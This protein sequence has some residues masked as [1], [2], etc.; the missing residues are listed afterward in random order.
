MKRISSSKA[1]DGLNPEQREAVAYI[2]G[3]LLILAGPGSGKTR[4]IT[5]KIAYLLEQGIPPRA[6]LGVTFTNKAAEEMRSRVET[7][8]GAQ[9]PLR[10]LWLH[11]FHAA[12]AR[13][14]RSHISMLSPKYTPGFTIFD[15]GDQRDAIARVMK[16]LDISAEEASPGFLVSLI[17]RAKDELVGPEDFARRYAGRLD[18]YL[19]EVASRVYR[20]YQALLES[21][22]AVDFGDLLRLTVELFRREPAILERYR[23]RFQYILI[24]EYQDINHAQYVFAKALAQGARSVAVVGDEDQAIFSWRGS[25]PSYILRFREDFPN[26]RVIALKRHYR[27]PH[28]D[29]IFKAAQRLIAHNTQRAREKEFLIEGTGEPIRVLVARDE[30]EEAQ[31]IARE[32]ARLEEQEGVD[33]SQI[34]VLYRINTLSRVIEEAL[35]YA[36]I[37]YEVVRGLRFYDR[38]EV[39]DLLAYLKLL[40]NPHDEISLLRA[41][42]RPRRGVGEASLRELQG[43]AARE[44]LSL[45]EAM[46]RAAQDPAGVLRPKAAQ[47]LKGFVELID[48]LREETPILPL[49]DLAE[50]VLERSGYLQE[51]LADPNRDERLGNVRELIGLLRT[52]ER[53][54]GEGASLTGFLEQVALLSD[55]DQYTGE[56]GRVALMTLHASKGLEFDVVFI[57]GVEENLLPHGRS[58]A[59]GML[60]EERRLFYVGMTRA[61]RRLYLSLA[62]QRTLYGNLLLNGPSRFLAELPEEDLVA[63]AGVG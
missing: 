40:A 7:L 30:L 43:L 50:N 42:S 59:E 10:D 37:P 4:V 52:Y 45:W 63:V 20:R 22:N 23:E 41:L 27:W 13:I 24:D 28:G 16:E 12:C 47:A 2:D 58:L 61:R 25:D 17:S 6:L 14:L 3:P 35:L 48:K 38:R 18:A 29:R 19:L 55:A 33:L 1:L 32:I 44:G 51:L 60:E 34:A 54:A 15:E 31:A 8:L 53:E 57:V 39:K 36:G 11:T 62:H 46:K 26:A 49:G 9:A 21:S 56:G 5:H